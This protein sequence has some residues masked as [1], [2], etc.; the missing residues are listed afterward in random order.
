MAFIVDNCTANGAR[1]VAAR[2]LDTGTLTP[3]AVGKA[4]RTLARGIT[5]NE[6]MRHYTLNAIGNNISRYLEAAKKTPVKRSAWR[7]TCGTCGADSVGMV[8][9]GVTPPP[10]LCIKAKW[11][12]CDGMAYPE[13]ESE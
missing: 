7:W 3:E 8:D 10:S 9:R 12:G 2:Y 4:M 13:C 6:R 11:G 5:G 1:K